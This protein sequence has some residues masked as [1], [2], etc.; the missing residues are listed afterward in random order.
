VSA[1]ILPTA[2]RASPPG[3]PQAARV[4]PLILTLALDEASQARFDALRQAHFPRERNHLQAHVTLFHALPGE[5]EQAVRRDLAQAARR[6]PF[7]VRVTGLRSLGRGVAYVLQAPELDRV[8]GALRAS[9]EPW[10]TPQD[11]ARHSPHVTVQ[12]KVDP[13]TA[14]ALLAELESGFAPYDVTATGLSLWRYLGG[15]WEPLVT[16]RFSSG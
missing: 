6:A 9:W 12:N 16:E 8:R 1:S 11:R 7:A 13:A 4:Q 2:R 15:P 10:L 3:V 5:Q 14:R